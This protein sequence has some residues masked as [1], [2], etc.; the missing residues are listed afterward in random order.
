MM[1]DGLF[2]KFSR[3]LSRGS[4]PH[5]TPTLHRGF[6]LRVCSPVPLEGSSSSFARVPHSLYSLSGLSFSSSQQA[7]RCHLPSLLR[8]HL[9][10]LPSSLG[11]FFPQTH[12]QSEMLLPACHLS[13]TLQ[14]NTSTFFRVLL[15]ITWANSL[16]NIYI[17]TTPEEFTG[18]TGSYKLMRLWMEVSFDLL[19]V[20]LFRRVWLTHL[21]LLSD[22]I[23]LFFVIT[24]LPSTGSEE[25]R[26]NLRC[27]PIS[28]MWV[29]CISENFRFGK[30]A[31]AFAWSSS[32]SISHSHS[33]NTVTTLPLYQLFYDFRQIV[34]SFN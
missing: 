22:C 30:M 20:I 12:S 25:S 9:H 15:S 27:A 7:Q 24:P 1:M 3:R 26:Q 29:I 5:S 14:T 19:Q 2:A 10:H 8:S 32:S 17:Y 23:D 13:H 33:L 28:E 34:T 11:F 18:I 31:L 4:F 6:W 16:H 21:P